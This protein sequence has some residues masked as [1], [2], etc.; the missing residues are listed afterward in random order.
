MTIRKKL[1][2]S[3]SISIIV[4]VLACTVIF[5]QLRNI[6][7]QYSDTIAL[8]FPQIDFTSDI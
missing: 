6:D 5:M 3:F 8:G 4:T 7:A 2:V 1:L